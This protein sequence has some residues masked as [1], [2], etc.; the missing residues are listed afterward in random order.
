MEM[1][2]IIAFFV[3]L[4]TRNWLIKNA[5]RITD[6]KRMISA[7]EAFTES[8]TDFEI[9]FLYP[10]LRKPKNSRARLFYF[11]SNILLLIIY[12]LLLIFIVTRFIV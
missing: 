9:L 3:S 5:K 2:L 8:I 7:F 4:F 10:I 11:Y 12:V 1:I 6:N